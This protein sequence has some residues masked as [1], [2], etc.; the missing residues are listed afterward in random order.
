V[1]EALG[2]ALLLATVVGSGIMAER[3][4]GGNQAIALL[5]NTIPTGAMLVVL[6]LIFGPIS[7]AHF[8]PLVTLT[9][10][11]RA[12]AQREALA[13]IPAQ[14]L[15]AVLG[16]WLAH[17]MFDEPVLQVS[18]K[19]R[20]GFGQIVSEFVATFGLIATIL[21]VARH[22]A[23]IVPWAVG[24]YITAAYW[25]TASTSFANPAVTIARALTNSFS[26][27]APAYL[28]PFIAA[29]AAGAAAAAGLFAW[30]HAPASTGE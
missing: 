18:L 24:L 10:F 2:T 7:G 22:R 20:A 21:G 12:E 4:A 26:G 29:Q 14:I 8:N 27:I 9:F 23:D 25:F 11:W 19:A 6:I 3:L 1:S 17:L 13:Y 28:L 15:G 30:L 16:V 5:G